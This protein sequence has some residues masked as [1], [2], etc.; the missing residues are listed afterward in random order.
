M[1]D[2]DVIAR[3]NAAAAAEQGITAARR[4]GKTVLVKYTGLHLVSSTEFDTP[5][6]ASAAYLER[7]A[8]DEVVCGAAHY[9]VLQPLPE[10]TLGDY[11]ARQQV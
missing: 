9:V 2:I 11:I 7:Q 10:Q 1:Q 3:Q 6:L 4:R 5:Q 8:D